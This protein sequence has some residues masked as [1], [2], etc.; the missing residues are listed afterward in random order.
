MDEPSNGQVV[1][2]TL[3]ETPQE[4]RSAKLLAESIRAFGGPLSSS[5]IWLF[6]GDP[7]DVPCGQLE[8]FGVRVLPL[9]VPDTVRGYLYAGKVCACRRAEE[10]ASSDVRTIVFLAPENLIVGPP[11]L[12]DLG[13]AFDVAARPVHIQNVGLLAT[14]ALDAFW[15]GVYE[16]VGVAD[17]E[18]TVESFVEARLLRA[19]FNSAAFAVRPATGLCRRWFEHFEALV[20]DEALQV[21]ACRDVWHQVFLHQAVL[22]ALIATTIDP[23]RLR[24]LPPD[25]VYPYNLHADVRADRRYAALNDLAS[26][27]YQDRPLDPHAIDDIEVRE[28]LRTWLL[29]RAGGE[30][31][32]SER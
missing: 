4:M 6:E 16:A 13:E 23:Q 25:Y 19:Y 21:S 3:V 30:G 17:I 20:C 32:A 24:L 11:L 9:S 2:V 12:F 31:G 27:Y 14:G 8:S 5:P 10:L 18:T 22:S 28:P 1:F 26:I 7:E 29:A 15:R